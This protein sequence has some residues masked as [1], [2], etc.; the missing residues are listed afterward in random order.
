MIDIRP[1]AAAALKQ[2]RPVVALESTLIAHGLPWPANIETA[3]EAEAAIRAEGAVPATIAVAA[4]VPV[5]GANAA[6]IDHLA[7]SGDVRKASRRDLALA[8][9]RRE[10]AATTV[11]ATMLLAHRAGIRAFAT[12]GIGGVHPGSPPDI[13]A[14][15]I[16]LGQAP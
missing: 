10:W 2:G 5:V 6:E 9:A 15:L 12:G 14:D 1:E 4:G 13:S 11:S 8:I 7:R 16:E 3:H